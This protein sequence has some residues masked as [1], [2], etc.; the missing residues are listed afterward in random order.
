MLK[1]KS[2][3][4]LISVL[5]IMLLTSGMTFAAYEPTR[6]YEGTT[7]SY[8]SFPH[9]TGYAEALN[10]IMEDFKKQTGI[11]VETTIIPWGEGNRKILSAMA[12][13]NA[14]DVMYTTPSRALPIIT[15]GDNVIE[16]LDDY[17]ENSDVKDEIIY[18]EA[19]ENYKWDG[20]TYALGHYGDPH[21]LAANLTVL[22]N[23]GVE[24]EY[25]EKM[26]DPDKVWTWEDFKY[27][28]KKTTRDTNGDGQVD[29]WGLAYPGGVNNASPFLHWYW[30]VG[31]KVVDTQGN[32]GIGGEKS[33]MVFELFEEI[34][35]KGYIIDGATNM[36]TSDN[37]NAFLDNKAA[38][39]NLYPAEA[40]IARDKKG[41]N[42][43]EIAAIYP[44]KAPNG[45]RGMFFAWNGV[46][47][48]ARS[49]NK[50][51]SWELIK[52]MATSDAYKK[53]MA[54]RSG[55]LTPVTTEEDIN[56]LIQEEY[57]GPLK[58]GLNAA[59]KGWYAR[60]EPAHPASAR[61]V[62]GYNSALQNI[63]SGEMTAEE[64][65]EWIKE[66]AETAVEEAE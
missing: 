55:R 33:K 5:A 26:T 66:E 59:E 51:A 4:I 54:E 9:G 20:T 16:P 18:S 32:I 49:D 63:L 41:E 22:R 8:Y 47:M 52:F 36:S 11:T 64:A 13:G 15:F 40:Y 50:G 12:A 53:L 60:H 10:N 17:I 45:K 37:D 2:L 31:G 34:N 35:N 19:L 25:I 23:A 21:T 27:M 7:I 1:K 65:N 62:R 58:V 57:R 39:T 44:P 24:E 48:S 43:P 38:F 46:M 14:P 42:L 3:L 6:E 30:N 61:I 56:T 28:L 29:Q